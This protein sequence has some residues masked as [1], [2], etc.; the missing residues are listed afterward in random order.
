MKTE[1]R[2]KRLQMHLSTAIWMMIAAGG[3]IW[4]HTREGSSLMLLCRGQGCVR[5]D[6][7]ILGSWVAIHFV[8]EV[9]ILLAVWYASEWWI[10]RRAPSQHSRDSV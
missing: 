8:V 6:E 10:R 2:R 7:S 4:V 1:P 3:L 5:I 9:C